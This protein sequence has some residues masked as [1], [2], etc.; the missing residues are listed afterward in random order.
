M[1]SIKAL[2][3]VGVVVAMVYVAF[4][5]VPPYFNNYQFQ[6][7]IES[8]ARL[9]SYGNKSEQEIREIIAKKAVEYSVPLTADQINVQRSGN[10]VQISA[11]YT[12][13]VDLPGYPLDLKFEPGTKSRRAY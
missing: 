11:R 3:G 12:I 10:E 6:D 8:E 9:A 2:A 5:L 1:K 13:H 7:A 4:L